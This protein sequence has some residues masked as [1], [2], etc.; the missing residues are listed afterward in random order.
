MAEWCSKLTDEDASCIISPVELSPAVTRS[1]LQLQSPLNQINN[2]I[3]QELHLW[4]QQTQYRLS[5]A[6]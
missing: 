2:P 3:S 1:T 5:V 4:T 6:D